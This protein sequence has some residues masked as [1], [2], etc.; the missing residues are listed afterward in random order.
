[1]SCKV[2]FLVGMVVWSA[3]CGLLMA[4]VGSVYASCSVS[5]CVQADKY[6]TANGSGGGSGW[7]QFVMVQGKMARDTYAVTGTP[8]KQPQP[9]GPGQLKKNWTS[10]TATNCTNPD[11]Q[12]G[13]TVVANSVS[14]TSTNYANVDYYLCK[15][16]S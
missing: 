2:C 4:M 7:H 14:G 3:I 13:T 8:K 6:G 10:G 9:S 12:S 16:V 5:E 11:P 15:P 1:M